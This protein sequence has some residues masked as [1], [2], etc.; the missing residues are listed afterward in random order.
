MTEL[1]SRT[2]GQG[3]GQGQGQG[4]D[5]GVIAAAHVYEHSPSYE[6][7]H[8]ESRQDYVLIAPHNVHVLASP[9]GVTGAFCGQL[10]V[11]QVQVKG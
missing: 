10:T 7:R 9:H 8:D 4:L 2:A 11:Q 3:P 1:M 5:D 6:V